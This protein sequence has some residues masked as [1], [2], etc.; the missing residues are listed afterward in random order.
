MR[1][2][3]RTI[4]VSL[5]VVGLIVAFWMLV[6]SPK[7]HEASSLKEDITQLQSSV[8]QAEQTA[9]AGQ[10]ARKAFGA[11]YRRLVV[12][13]KAVPADDDQA[14]LLVQIERLANRAG[15]RF[16]AIS[17]TDASADTT[18]TA[19]PTAPAGSTESSAPPAAPPA[20][21]TAATATEATAATLP[22]GATVG[23]AGLPVM[24][25]DLTF[26]G[27]FFQIADFLQGLDGM[28]HTRQAKVDVNGR[29]LTVDA[30]TLEPEQ[31]STVGASLD[32]TP[33]LTASLA[34]TTYL[35]PAEQGITAGATPAAPA[36]ATPAPASPTPASSTTTTTPTATATPTPSSPAPAP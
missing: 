35:T 18:A 28:V 14:S 9:A 27:E 25:Y 16:Q 10:Q 2:A 23:P 32:P 13:G 12:L 31:T 5:A 20:E 19:T 1:R 33:V 7:R 30:F 15:V 26:T 29:L 6:I 21:P 36:P 22:I 3:D 34:V 11:N 24:P 8:D 17:L 4:V